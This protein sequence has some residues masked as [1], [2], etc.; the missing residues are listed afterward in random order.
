MEKAYTKRRVLLARDLSVRMREAREGR[1]ANIACVGGRTCRWWRRT[2]EDVSGLRIRREDRQSTEHERLWMEET[3]A[4]VAGK[5][6]V[7]AQAKQ[8][9]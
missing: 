7:D 6:E 4:R 2:K 1:K 5:G 3:H 8:G 9:I